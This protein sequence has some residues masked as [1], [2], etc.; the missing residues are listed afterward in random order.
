MT[1]GVT[2]CTVMTWLQE[3]ELPQL[4]VAV[5]VLVIVYLPGQLPGI[6]ESV[7]VSVG[8]A[9]QL[10]VAVAVPVLPGSIGSLQFTVTAGGQTI[11]GGVVS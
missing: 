4:S 7:Y 8:I 10:S 5:H 11:T 3:E 9:S 2:S 1:G 6:V